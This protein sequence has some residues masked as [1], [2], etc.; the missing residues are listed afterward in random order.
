V[1]CPTAE[2]IYFCKRDWTTQITLKQQHKLLFTRS[3]FSTRDPRERSGMQ[4]D[5]A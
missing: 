5:F 2:A 1:I 4:A 3:G